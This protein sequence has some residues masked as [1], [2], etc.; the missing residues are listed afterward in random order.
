[1]SVVE[2]PTLTWGEPG[3]ERRALVVHGLG[4]D[5]RTMWRI[6]EHLA[7]SGWCAIAIDQRGHGR[8]PRTSSY[9]IEEYAR[10]ILAVP[11]DE[12]WDVVIAHSIAGASVVVASNMEPG[13]AERLVLIDPA[14]ATTPA[15]RDEILANQIRNHR[16]LTVERQRELFPH[17][18]AQD[19]ES[20]VT[21][22]RAASEFALEHSVL[23]NPDWDVLALAERITVPTLVVQGDP[24]VVAR[25]TDEHAARIESAN[26]LVTRTMI[27]GTGHNVHRD[28]PDE[29]CARLSAWL[30]A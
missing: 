20:S 28:A 3:A 21:A 25:Y 19:I 26:P 24:A 18:H 2:L 30:D 23:D 14:L 8:A 10:D 12:P 29:F 17:W 22:V 5:S 27:P 1:M 6:G 15:N 4:S 7:N 16:E 9:R 13:F 11:H